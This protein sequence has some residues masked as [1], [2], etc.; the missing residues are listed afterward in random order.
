MVV[1]VVVVQSKQNKN[2]N[3]KSSKLY[4][5]RF[6]VDIGQA[7]QFGH[8][9]M[10]GIISTYAYHVRKHSPF[11]RNSSMALPNSRLRESL[12]EW[13]GLTQQC[14]RIRHNQA[15]PSREFAVSY[16]SPLVTRLIRPCSS[17][18]L[19]DDGRFLFLRFV[20]HASVPDTIG[21]W[22][23]LYLFVHR[24]THMYEEQII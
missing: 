14:Q 1:V 12:R 3:N 15:P 11:K 18:W 16:V 10:M 2:T 9:G 6:W 19:K 17:H 22:E 5:V 8:V 7:T 23:E 4:I 24:I 20:M 21:L 13:N